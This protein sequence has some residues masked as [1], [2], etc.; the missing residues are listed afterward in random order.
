ME[1]ARSQPEG[2]PTGGKERRAARSGAH[3][4]RLLLRMPESLH[5]ELAKAS[6]SEGVSLN[7]F[8][9]EV[10]ASAIG[11]EGSGLRKRGNPRPPAEAAAAAPKRRL[12]PS[13]LVANLLVV[14]AVGIV[15]LVLLFEA[16]L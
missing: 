11:W 1:A 8:I 10:L 4:G 12:L 6:Q 16:L 9:T 14:G 15:A 13:L 7:A 2:T 5:A 3:S